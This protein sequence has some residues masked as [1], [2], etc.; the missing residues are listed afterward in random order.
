LA[1]QDKEDGMVEVAN[2]DGKLA[3]RK[4]H[5]CRRLESK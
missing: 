4:D 2:D 1:A 3:L 5:L